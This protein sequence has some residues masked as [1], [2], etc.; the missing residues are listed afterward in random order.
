MHNEKYEEDH[1]IELSP[2]VVK[3]PGLIGTHKEFDS[4][5]FAISIEK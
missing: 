1:L 3:L 2:R 5:Y 4:Q